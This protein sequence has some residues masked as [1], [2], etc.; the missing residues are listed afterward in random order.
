MHPKCIFAMPS[1]FSHFFFFYL[2]S[3]TKTKLYLTD[4]SSSKFEYH[5]RWNG[6][7]DGTSQ[8]QLRRENRCN[9]QFCLLMVMVM[10][11]MTFEA[12]LKENGIKN[13]MR[14]RKGRK[15]ER[16]REWKRVFGVQVT[17]Y[18]QRYKLKLS[19]TRVWC[20]LISRTTKRT[21]TC[22]HL[23]WQC[24]FVMWQKSVIK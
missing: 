7:D 9:T 14:K 6:I 24:L 11:M 4:G 20:H 12:P 19:A 13:N 17:V 21:M 1:Y 23:L 18:K 10:M 8:L 22:A 16:E 2:P 3:L 15:D 5:W